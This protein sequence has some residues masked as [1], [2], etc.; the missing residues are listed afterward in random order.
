QFIKTSLTSNIDVSI[1]I[2]LGLDLNEEKAKTIRSHNTIIF[3]SDEIY[4]SRLFLQEMEGIYSA[5]ELTID[6]LK[7]LG[8]INLTVGQINL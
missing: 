6:T 7:K 4:Q 5:S 8:S 1:E 3:V 2:T